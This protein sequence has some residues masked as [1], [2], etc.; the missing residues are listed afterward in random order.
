MG[1]KDKFCEVDKPL[2]GVFQKEKRQNFLMQFGP[3]VGSLF[4]VETNLMSCKIRFP[5]KGLVLQ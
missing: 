5:L 3:L 1:D 2:K 4:C